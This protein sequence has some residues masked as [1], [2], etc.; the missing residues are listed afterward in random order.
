MRGISG[1][2]TGVVK[3]NGN[4]GNANDDAN[5][6]AGGDEKSIVILRFLDGDA[7]EEDVQEL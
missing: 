2:M 6:D 1:V 4:D 5:G 3:E 7:N